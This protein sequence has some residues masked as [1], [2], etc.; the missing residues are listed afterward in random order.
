MDGLLIIGCGNE[1]AGDDAAGVEI[2]RRVVERY[3]EKY[4]FHAAP[5]VAIELLEILAGRDWAIVI[6]AVASG[7]PPGTIHVVALHAHSLVTRSLGG[8]SS[9][10]FGLAEV[11]GFAEKLGRPMPKLSLIG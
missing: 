11:L 8:V 9:H 7:A 4:E 6:D 5:R 10:G 3:G 2:V 1:F